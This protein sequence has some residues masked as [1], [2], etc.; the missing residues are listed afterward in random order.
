ML[1]QVLQCIMNDMKKDLKYGMYAF[2]LCLFIMLFEYIF[3]CKIHFSMLSLS[4]LVGYCYIIFALTMLNRAAGTR[5]ALQLNLFE[6]LNLKSARSIAY[7][8]ENVMLFIPFGFLLPAC[9][10]KLRH[11]I[12]CTLIGMIYSIGIEA[13]QYYTKRGFTQVDDVAANTLGTFLGALVFLILFQ[14]GQW[15]FHPR[16]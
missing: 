12:P 3:F 4:L 2:V 9:F 10:K 11:I 13:L 5:E 1:N 7:I 16:R 14:L 8:V 6:T 15:L